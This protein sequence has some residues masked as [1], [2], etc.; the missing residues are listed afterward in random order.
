MLDLRFK[1]WILISSFIGRE[2]EW[3][4]VEE[5]DRKSLFPMLLKSYH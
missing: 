1:S 2:H 5:Y 3:V 4:I